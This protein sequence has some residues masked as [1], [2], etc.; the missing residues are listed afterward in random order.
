MI[1]VES[2]STKSSDP[3]WPADA[4]LEPGVI[5]GY[6]SL[7][8]EAVSIWAAKMCCAQRDQKPLDEESKGLQ[9]CIRAT[10]CLEDPFCS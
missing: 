3:E 2:K 4:D 8:W 1:S 10:R 5:L 9:H 7:L 6:N